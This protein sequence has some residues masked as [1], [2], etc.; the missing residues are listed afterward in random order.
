MVV[1]YVLFGH[2]KTGGFRYGLSCFYYTF[3]FL[4][5]VHF[6]ACFVF[7]KY[8]KYNLTQYCKYNLTQ[9][10]TWLHIKIGYFLFSQQMTGPTLL[11]NLNCHL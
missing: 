11:K 7:S 8:C 3:F 6:V 5:H 10:S 9:Y 2:W 4:T 1:T